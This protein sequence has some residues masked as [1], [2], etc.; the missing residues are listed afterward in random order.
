MNYSY[1][2]STLVVLE[3]ELVHAVVVV[4]PLELAVLKA[5]AVLVG[6]VVAKTTELPVNMLVTLAVAIF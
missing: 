4:V 6:V 1:K 3:G 2:G 5:K